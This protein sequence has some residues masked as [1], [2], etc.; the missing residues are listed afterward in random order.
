MRSA[1][2]DDF[3]GVLTKDIP[4]KLRSWDDVLFFLLEFRAD[5]T[6]AGA[7]ALIILAAEWHD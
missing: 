2:D 6:A 3:V 4:N 7:K 1:Q 5:S